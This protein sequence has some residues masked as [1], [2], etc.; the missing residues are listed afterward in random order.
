MLLGVVAGG[1]KTRK[2]TDGHHRAGRTRRG[3]TQVTGP[4]PTARRVGGIEPGANWLFGRSWKSFHGRGDHIEDRKGVGGKV[5]ICSNFYGTNF[6]ETPRSPAPEIPPVVARG[7]VSHSATTLPL[8]EQGQSR[9]SS[10]TRGTNPRG[11]RCDGKGGGEPTTHNK[12]KFNACIF[13]KI[14][15]SPL[16]STLLYL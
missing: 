11:V 9:T 8:L 7:G 2:G 10:D 6:P 5:P 1:G 15:S 16:Y 14:E 13:K 4:P 12:H 3:A